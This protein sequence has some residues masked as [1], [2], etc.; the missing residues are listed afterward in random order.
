MLVT[1]FLRLQAYNHVKPVDIF[2]SYQAIP[3]QF[4]ILYYQRFNMQFS[5]PSAH[6]HT[7]GNRATMQGAGLH[8]GSNLG[9]SILPKDK[10]NMWTGG[11]RDQTANSDINR[12]PAQPPEPQLPHRA[13][14]LVHNSTKIGS[15][16]L[17]TNQHHLPSGTEQITLEYSLMDYCTGLSGT[18]R[19][20]QRIGG[21]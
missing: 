10:H 15:Q 14:C 17:D 13:Q 18:G 8:K 6:T 1:L 5:S 2:C 9:F 19:G 12:Q 7:D 20:D 11:A 21:P 16:N 3:Q 4:S